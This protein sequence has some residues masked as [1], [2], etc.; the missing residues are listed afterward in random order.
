MLPR[1]KVVYL[2]LRHAI[3][4]EAI[5]LVLIE[6]SH[7]SEAGS[8]E[9]EIKVLIVLRL[10]CLV[11]DAHLLDDLAVDFLKVLLTSL[12]RLGVLELALLSCRGRHVDGRV[13][14][15]G[16]IDQNIFFQFL[17]GY[18]VLN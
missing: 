8:L 9:E 3:L 16:F 1:G 17:P 4:I 10:F 15:F 5:E 6:F 12:L 2:E 7:D 18:P 13:E 14:I 11:R